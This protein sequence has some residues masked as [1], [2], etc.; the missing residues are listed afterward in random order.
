MTNSEKSALKALNT[1]AITD[2][3][4][5]K[6]IWGKFGVMAEHGTG[7]TFADSLYSFTAQTIDAWT[8]E[9]AQTPYT[10]DTWQ[11]GGVSGVLGSVTA[12][13]EFLQKLGVDTEN[14]VPTHS[15]TNEQRD[16]LASRHDLNALTTM[17]ANDPEFG[18]I[19]ADL[20]YLNIISESEALVTARVNTAP[21][22]SELIYKNDIASLY[23]LINNT[24]ETDEDVER[25]DAILKY[26]DKLIEI[27]RE[28]LKEKQEQYYLDFIHGKTDDDYLSSLVSCHN[29]ISQLIFG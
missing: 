23:R 8:P 28:R 5:K 27:E 21:P 19:M 12:A 6:G 24:E 22:N 4:I 10:P 9:G 3:K 29:M 16:W 13:K 17:S 26:L 18:N 11:T 20:Y 14:R 15:V 1:H 25:A 7:V 2:H